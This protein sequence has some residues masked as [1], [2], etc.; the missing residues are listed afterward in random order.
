[1]S[2]AGSEASHYILELL[3]WGNG[4]GQACLPIMQRK[5]FSSK[6]PFKY[7]LRSIIVFKLKPE[8]AYASVKSVGTG[9]KAQIEV[10]ILNK[11]KAK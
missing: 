5:G 3:P 11:S 6:F 7:E 1:M 9:L 2:R 10:H 4:I 8:V